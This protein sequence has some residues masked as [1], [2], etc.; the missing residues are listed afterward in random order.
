V[1]PPSVVDL[2]ITPPPAAWRVGGKAAG[3]ARLASL[4]LPVPR[5]FAITTGAFEEFCSHNRIDLSGDGPEVARTIE[6]GSWPERLRAEVEDALGRIP[7][8]VVAV[9][10]SAGC[11]DGLRFSLAGQFATFLSVPRAEVLDRVVRCWSSLFSGSARS[12][13]ARMPPGDRRMAVILQE[14]VRPAWS[15]VAFSLDPVSRSFDA[16]AVEWTTGPGADLV[17]GRVVPNRLALPRHDGILPGEIPSPLRPHLRTL[18]A[19]VARIEHAF[20]LPVDVEWCATEDQLFLLQARP[21]TTVGGPGD[22]LWSN[23][24]LAENFPAPLAPLAWSFLH[25]FYA[26]YIRAVLGL[27]G[28]RRREFEAVQHLLS[29]V[30][31]I[32]RG[33]IHY[34]LTT[35]YRIVSYFP[36]SGTFTSF[37]DAYIGQEVPIR[38]PPDGRAPAVR[39]RN[40]GPLG[41]LRFLGNLAFALASAGRR[42]AA[43]ERRL[44]ERR[45]AWRQALLEAADPRASDEVLESVIDL[46]AE[47]WSGPCAADLAVMILPGLLGELAERWCGRPRSEVLP[48][49]LQ[50]VEVKSEEPARMLWRLARSSL[51]GSAGGAGTGD[52]ASWRSGLLEDDAR[53]F[54]DFLHRFGARCYADCSLVSATF[55]ERPDLAF[56]LVRRFAGAPDPA[57]PELRRASEAGREELLDALC[58]PLDPARA[59]LLRQVHRWSLRAIQLREEGRLLQ[60]QLFGEARLAIRR[61]GELLLRSQVLGSPEEIFDLTWEEVRALANGSYPYPECLPG[62]LAERRRSREAWADEP[63]PALFVMRAGETLGRDGRGPAPANGPGP[64]GRALSGV[65]VSRGKAR[66]RARVLRDP[67]RETLERGEILVAPSADPGWTPLILLAGGLVLERGGVLSHGAIV[68]REAGIPGLVQVPDACRA[69]ADGASVVL[70]GDAGTVSVESCD[71]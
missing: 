43:L 58:R 48:T 71:A 63:P 16:M 57:R 6:A 1:S 70:D 45:R 35:W 30:T 37:L 62:L 25:R 64:Q 51:P 34:D 32:H 41:R 31:G 4:G 28:W 5:C 29:T 59:R 20:A 19:H 13:L 65:V 15:G 69:I 60:S 36:W 67:S 26:E 53:L 17:A 27:L 47:G 68:A 46:V 44:E 21:V 11:E 3:L 66:G 8:E 9:R 38:P 61:T 55:T 42:L 49:L 23:V 40:H 12:Y 24:N 18:R 56:E 22:V 2:A 54:E 33:R 10:S 7:G 50:G 52:Y 39:R 14:Q